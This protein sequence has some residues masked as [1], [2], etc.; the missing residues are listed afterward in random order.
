MTGN[1]SR[2]ST[3]RIDT[4]DR[5]PAAFWLTLSGEADI[6]TLAELEEALARVHLHGAQSVHLHLA[7]LKFCGV[8]TIDRLSN[9]ARHARRA[10]HEVM[11]CRANLFVHRVANLLECRQELGLL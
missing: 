10:G 4:T 6:A 7:D 5:G 1:S 8:E 9:F 11:S 3:L 2:S